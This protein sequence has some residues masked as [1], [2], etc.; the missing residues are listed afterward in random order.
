MW[1]KSLMK[2]LGICRKNVKNPKTC[3]TYSVEFVVFRDEDDYQPLLGGPANKNAN[4]PSG[5]KTAKFPPLRS[6]LHREEL[7]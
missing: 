4:G 1:N 2:P 7:Q 6:S 5:D 3:K